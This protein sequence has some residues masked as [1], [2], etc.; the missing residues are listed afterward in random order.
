MLEVAAT[1]DDLRDTTLGP[2]E[3]FS[4]RPSAV[5]GAILTGLVIAL[6][7]LAPG[8]DL[9]LT[10]G[11]NIL[12]LLLTGVGALLVCMTSSLGHFQVALDPGIARTG[13]DIHKAI[14]HA[15]D[16]GIGGIAQCIGDGRSCRCRLF[17]GGS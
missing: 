12:D 2:G 1:F 14:G 6:L 8:F 9:A 15:L 7:A 3:D 10:L 4:E 5:S 17:D 11:T 16:H 13:D